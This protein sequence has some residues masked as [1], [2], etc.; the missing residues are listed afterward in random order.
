[1]NSRSASNMPLR[2]AAAA[3]IWYPVLVV[4]DE[5][6]MFAPSVGGDV[7]EDE[8]KMSLGA[9]TNLMC[10]GRKRGLAGVIATQRLAKL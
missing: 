2:K 8:R 9:M 3:R 10:R 1:Q 4:V 6:Q 5:A 7:S